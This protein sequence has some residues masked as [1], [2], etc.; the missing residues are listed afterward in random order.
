ML[1]EIR[2]FEENLKENMKNLPEDADPASEEEMAKLWEQLS[3]QSENGEDFFP[4]FFLDIMQKLLAKDVLYPPLKDLST[5]VGDKGDYL[6]QLFALSFASTLT[7]THH[8]FS[9]RTGCPRIKINC[10]RR[11]S[12]DTANSMS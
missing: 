1:D 4:P 6:E 12:S 11:T 8:L 7:S 10:P 9:S 5:K 3:S 2:K